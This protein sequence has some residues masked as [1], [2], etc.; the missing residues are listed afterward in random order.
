MFKIDIPLRL[1][2]AT[3]NR[4]SQ[5]YKGRPGGLERAAQAESND[6][7]PGDQ[8]ANRENRQKKDVPEGGPDRIYVFFC[9]IARAGG[10]GLLVALIL[11]A[12]PW[13]APDIQPFQTRLADF[14]QQYGIPICSALLIWFGVRAAL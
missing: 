5:F 4:Y 7:I 12:I 3:V 11:A 10:I 13:F 2:R 8:T 14:I 6:L 1:L 9:G